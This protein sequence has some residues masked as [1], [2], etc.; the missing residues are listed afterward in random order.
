MSGDRFISELWKQDLLLYMTDNQGEMKFEAN[1]ENVR[2]S[3]LK[4]YTRGDGRNT[5]EQLADI[6]Q[7]RKSVEKLF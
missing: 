1:E 4:F 2:I 7:T 6:V 3:G 5:M